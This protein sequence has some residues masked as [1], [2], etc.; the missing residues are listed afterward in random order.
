MNK[1]ELIAAAAAKAGTTQKDA[2]AVINAALETLTPLW[3]MV[4]V[5]RFPASASSRSRLAKLALAA[6]PAPRRPSRSPLLACP[7]S[8]PA[9]L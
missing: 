5:C 4:T 9:R 8:R 6:T 1:K 3:S 2:E 7:L